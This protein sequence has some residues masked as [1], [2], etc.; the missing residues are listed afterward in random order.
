[1][2]ARTPTTSPLTGNP[3]DDPTRHI[4]VEGDA[5]DCAW[6]GKPEADHWTGVRRPAVGRP[7]LRN[8]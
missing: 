5:L 6:C 3:M 7:W 2:T 8:R 4:Y 1:M